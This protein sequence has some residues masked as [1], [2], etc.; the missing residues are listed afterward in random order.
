[1]EEP[2][3]HVVMKNS[4]K[5]PMVPSMYPKIFRSNVR[6]IRTLEDLEKISFFSKMFS[7]DL[8]YNFHQRKHF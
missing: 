1:M 8:F 2:M 7:F 3:L 5:W 6:K 4:S